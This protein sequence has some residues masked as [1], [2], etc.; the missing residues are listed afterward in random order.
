MSSGFTKNLLL[1]FGSVLKTINES[2]GFL[3]TFI[4]LIY[5]FRIIKIRH[6]KAPCDGRISFMVDIG[7]A[8]KKKVKVISSSTSIR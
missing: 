5:H 2:T 6:R 7:W 3:K 4:L 1:L 8:N